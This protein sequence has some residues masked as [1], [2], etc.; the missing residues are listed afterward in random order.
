MFGPIKIDKNRSLPDLSGRELW[1]FVPLIALIF[2]M[3]V[4]PKPFIA[5]MEPSI[6]RTLK[7][8]QVKY[9]ASRDFTDPTPRRIGLQSKSRLITA[10]ANT[11]SMAKD[12]QR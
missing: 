10:E 3:G 8:F 12:T 9:D 4:Y 6:T 7:E 2:V 11:H 5:R 1:T